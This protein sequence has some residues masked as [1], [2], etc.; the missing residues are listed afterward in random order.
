MIRFIHAAD[1]HLDT[2]FRGLE[3]TSKRLAEKLREA[4]FESFA[5]IMDV[6]IDKQVDFVLLSGDLY[7]TKR[8]NIKAQSLFI[9]QL[10][11]LAKEK[12]PVYLIRGNHDYLTEE[13]KTLALPFPENV[14]TFGPKVE[15]HI[16]N[17]KNNERVAISG[18]SYESQW[19]TERKIKDYPTKRPDVNLHIGML[20]GDIETSLTREANYAPFTVRELREKNLDYWALGHVHQRQQVSVEPLAEYPGNI[21][22]LHKNET[23]E[24]GCLFVEWTPREQKVEFIQT[25]PVIWETIGLSL[26]DIKNISE[27]LETLKDQIS[28]NSHSQDVLVHLNITADTDSEEELISFIQEKE[29]LEQLSRQLGFDNVWI[30]S[31]DLVMQ[32]V[33]N[34]QA[35]EHIYPE[36]WDLMLGKLEKPGAFNMITEN[37]FSQIPTRYLNETNSE[38][39]RKEIIQKAIAKLYL[40]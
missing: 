14:R 12:I 6:A 30:A 13:S 22:G 16:L 20:H 7:N 34:Q 29:F 15:T 25:A 37:I 32:E 38:E 10:N 33:S 3:Q 18:F 9:E 36:E 35:L 4:P 19:V 24:K 28:K 11:R 40:K 31:V 2:P 5:R 21:Q 23:G 39:Y 8:V 26:S 1:L 27:F 17:T